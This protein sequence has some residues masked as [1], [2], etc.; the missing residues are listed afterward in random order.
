[1]GGNQGHGVP[2]GPRNP[3]LTYLQVISTVELFVV[4]KIPG[5]KIKR[6]HQSVTKKIKRYKRL[7]TK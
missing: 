4:A 1:M 3:M 7:C 5:R 6:T 2:G